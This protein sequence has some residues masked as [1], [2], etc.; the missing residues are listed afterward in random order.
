MVIKIYIII[1]STNSVSGSNF[2]DY[3][4][5]SYK[6]GERY[7]IPN[8]GF[9]NGPQPW[10]EWMKKAGK[11]LKLSK[12]LTRGMDKEDTDL[13]LIRELE[14]EGD[15]LFKVY[16]QYELEKMMNGMRSVRILRPEDRSYEDEQYK[17]K[18]IELA[19]EFSESIKDRLERIRI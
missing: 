4:S 14:P 17:T 6:E 12:D 18:F 1:T 13:R 10:I 8:S 9:S 2:D 7:S 3:F 15:Y 5:N 11:E 19:E 16:L